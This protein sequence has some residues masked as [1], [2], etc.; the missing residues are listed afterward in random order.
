MALAMKT[1]LLQASQN[2]VQNINSTFCITPK[3]LNDYWFSNLKESK[4]KVKQ[5]NLQIIS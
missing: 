3:I 4:P 5:K 1:K 2:L